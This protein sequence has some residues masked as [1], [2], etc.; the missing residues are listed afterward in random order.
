MRRVVVTGIGILSSILG[1]IKKE[2]LD[3]PKA[4]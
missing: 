1:S 4:G 3:S 2:V